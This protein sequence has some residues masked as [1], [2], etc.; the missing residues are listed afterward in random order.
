MGTA[1]ATSDF[2]S[3]KKHDSAVLAHVQEGGGENMAQGPTYI[4]SINTFT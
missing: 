3:G 4:G 1:V 2:T